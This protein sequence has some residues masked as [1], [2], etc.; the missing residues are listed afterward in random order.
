MGPVNRN[1]FHPLQSGVTAAI[2]HKAYH[3]EGH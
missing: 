2:N 3:S 1:A